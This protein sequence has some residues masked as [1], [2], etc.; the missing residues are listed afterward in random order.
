[1]FDQLLGCQCV[2]AA[3]LA[4]RIDERVQSSVREPT[5]TACGCTMEQLH[6]DAG[7]QAVGG[8]AVLGCQPGH[9][10]CHRPM[11]ADHAPVHPGTGCLLQALRLLV[12]DTEG[13]DERQPGRAAG[14]AVPPAEFSQQCVRNRVTG[15]GASDRYRSAVLDP[16][17][18]LRGGLYRL[19]SVR[20][21][22]LH[23]KLR[24]RCCQEVLWPSVVQHLRKP[25]SRL[26]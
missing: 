14:R 11:A 23:G 8:E 16:K 4:S 18:R 15:A 3:A 25:H 12:T 13:M 22:A 1:M 21:G 7:G 9:L 6:H 17:H 10:R 26:R 20:A 2:Q 19:L 5:G 24:L